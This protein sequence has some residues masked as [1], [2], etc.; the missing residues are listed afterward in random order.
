M[1]KFCQI[2]LPLKQRFSLGKLKAIIKFGNLSKKVRYKEAP[3]GICFKTAI[4]LGV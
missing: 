3:S 1:S 2:Q 4:C